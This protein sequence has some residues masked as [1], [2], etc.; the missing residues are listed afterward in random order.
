MKALLGRA[1]SVEPGWKISGF[2]IDDAA[3]EIDPIRQDIFSIQF[4]FIC[5][6]RI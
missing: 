2:L 1:S 3:A 5:G 4:V 6:Y